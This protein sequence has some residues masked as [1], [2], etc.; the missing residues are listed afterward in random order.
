MEKSFKLCSALRGLG[1]A[2]LHRISKETH[3]VPSID[4]DDHVFSSEHFVNLKIT[5][6]L[7]KFFHK[8]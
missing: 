5:V 3:V 2:S 4:S 8:E 1:S 6:N 7:V